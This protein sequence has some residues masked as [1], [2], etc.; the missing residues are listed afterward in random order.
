MRKIAYFLL[1]MLSINNDAYA[2]SSDYQKDFD[3]F[4]AF[5]NEG[6]M[7]SA[8]YILLNIEKDLTNAESK[9]QV[10]EYVRAMYLLSIVYSKQNLIRESERVIERAEKE[11]SLRGDEQSPIMRYLIMQRGMLRM[12]IGDTNDAKLYFL[13]AKKLF[14]KEND[15]NSIE[16]ISCLTNIGNIYFKEGL[17]W[18]S[19]IILKKALKIISPIISTNDISIDCKLSYVKILN[20]ISLNYDE[21]GDYEQSLKI[22]NGII[23]YAEK[24]QLLDSIHDVILNTLYTETKRG[25]YKIAQKYLYTINEYNWEFIEKD[26][27]YPNFIVPLYFL[28]DVRIFDLLEE[29]IVYSKSNLVSIFLSFS[30]SER[31]K[32]A[33]GKCEMMT[34]LTNALCLKYQTKELLKQSYDISLFTKT[35]ITNFSKFLISYAKSNPSDNLRKK[36]AD[37]TELKKTVTKKD[38]SNDIY[39]EDVDK[40]K[41]LEREIVSS[42]GNYKDIF[43][44]SKLKWENIRN[45]LKAGEA[46]IEFNMFSELVTE[47]RAIIPYLGALIIRSD[48]DS[49]IFVRLCKQSDLNALLRKGSK[50]DS[51]LIEELYNIANDKLYNCIFKPIE[52]HLTGCKTVFFSP[53]GKLHKI[54]IQA[55]SNNKERLMDRYDFIEVSSTAKLLERKKEMF[56]NELSSAFVVGGVDYN[57]DLEEMLLEANKYSDYSPNFDLATR[58][59]YRGM[60]DNIPGTLYEAESIDSLLH[61]HE[62]KS[63]FL[64]GKNANE[65]SIKVLNCHSPDIIHIATHGFFYEK[66]EESSTHF[67][68]NTNSYTGKGFPMKYSGLLFAGANNAWTGKTLPNNIEDGILTAEEIS[69]MDLANTKLVVLSACDTGLGEIE[70]VDGVYGLQR[71]FKMAGA[72][73]IVMSLWKI[74]DDATSILMVEFYKN[75]MNGKTKNQSLKDA[76]KHLRQVENGKYDKPEYWASFIM[77]DGLN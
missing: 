68:D 1:I 16:Y 59:S 34:F 42:I 36:Y 25:N 38:L 37:L 28:N 75:L 44:D 56:A 52:R 66:K 57:E 58:S 70:N 72:E 32:Y 77:L 23:S 55:I 62:L 74:S 4:F 24:N 17:F 9:F 33:Y 30:E 39:L 29:Y 63:I 14:E 21:M 45:C 2:S 35:M 47:D 22:R 65:E 7:D 11:I 64:K 31:E 61:N 48:S 73:T 5:Y 46:A 26:F 12:L 19:N 71:G 51:Q 6:K 8:A 69:Q 3:D 67:F 27:V 20:G 15:C 76:Q 49:P 13:K 50:S 40:I 60:W 54:N 43:D 53:V 41:K 10:K 18:T